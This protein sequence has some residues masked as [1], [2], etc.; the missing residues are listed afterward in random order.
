MLKRIFNLKTVFPLMIIIIAILGPLGILELFGI[1]EGKLIIALIG[2]LALNNFIE[3]VVILQNIEEKVTNIDLFKNSNSEF[4]SFDK[5]LPDINNFINGNKEIILGGFS[6]YR[7]LTT[8]ENVFINAIIKKKVKITFCLL[9]PEIQSPGLIVA[10]KRSLNFPTPNNLATNVL[11]SIN[12]IQSI[13]ENLPTNRKKYLRLFLLDF[14][15]PYSLISIDGG[16]EY[17]VIFGE[18]YSLKVSPTDSPAFVLRKANIKWYTYFY[19]QAKELI[20]NG[21]EYDLSQTKINT[22][23]A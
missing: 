10:S 22:T 15:P 20:K 7:T 14:T 21:H 11:S 19:K 1:K 8:Y 2:F 6:L 18:I 4:L 23:T 9:N 16:E 5:G 13:Y 17:G 3:R 12:K